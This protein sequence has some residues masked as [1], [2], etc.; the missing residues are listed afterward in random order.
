M[1]NFIAAV[2]RALP[3]LAILAGTVAV[4]VGA[5]M[6]SAAFGCIVGGLLLLALGLF[7]GEG[8]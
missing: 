1:K 5:A 4:T 8:T 7:G 3:D 2:R 6:L